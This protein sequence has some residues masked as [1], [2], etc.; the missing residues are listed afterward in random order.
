[1]DQIAFMP[2]FIAD[3]FLVYTTL[4]FGPKEWKSSPLIARNL[5]PVMAILVLG[6]LVAH[7]AF[8]VQF[9]GISD[10]IFWAGFFS[11]T[12]ISWSS[13]AQLLSRGSTRGNSWGIWWCRTFG[14]LS[15][16]GWVE[17]RA[18]NYPGDWPEGHSFAHTPSALFLT[19]NSALVDFIYPLV[20]TYVDKYE[21]RQKQV[22]A[23]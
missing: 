20:Y 6:T 2:V 3:F 10:A 16:V 7:W 15:A 19:M 17:M 12:I 13:I 1:M 8:M 14:T 21:R 11:Q 9:K 23:T 5:A 4:K 18:W 22:K